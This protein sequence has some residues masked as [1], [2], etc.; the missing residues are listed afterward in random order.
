MNLQRLAA[1]GADARFESQAVEGTERQAE[2]EPHAGL[3]LMEGLHEGEALLVVC[4][5][6]YRGIAKSPLHLSMRI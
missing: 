4:A 1:D 3:D 5:S 6:D 2:E